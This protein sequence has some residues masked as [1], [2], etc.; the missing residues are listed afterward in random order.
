[1]RLRPCRVAVPLRP[2]TQAL[3]GRVAWLPG[4]APAVGVPAPWLVEAELA[5]LRQELA[6]SPGG[7]EAAARIARRG[8]WTWLAYIQGVLAWD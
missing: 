8:G 5:L 7:A 4:R 6:G 1:M 3:G 2:S